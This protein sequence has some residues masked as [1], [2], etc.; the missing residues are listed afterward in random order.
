MEQPIEE[1]IVEM[2]RELDV[3]RG[4]DAPE[5]N[6]RRDD[7]YARLR[8]IGATAAFYGGYDA[9]KQLH[10]AVELLVGNTNK[11]GY[12]ISRA[13]DKIGGWWD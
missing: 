2:T 4:Q 10:D 11:A 9:M 5:V 13:W 3:L 12:Y 6:A 1:A 7:L 8:L